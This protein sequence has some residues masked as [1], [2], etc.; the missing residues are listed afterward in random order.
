M[1]ERQTRILQA[2]CHMPNHRDIFYGV[3]SMVVSKAPKLHMGGFFLHLSLI[4][5]ASSLQQH[6]STS[7]VACVLRP[8]HGSSCERAIYVGG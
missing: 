6:R 7:S 5:F 1:A 8:H 4:A 3:S 2:R